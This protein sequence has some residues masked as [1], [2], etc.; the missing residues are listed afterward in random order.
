M[1]RFTFSRV[2]MMSPSDEVAEPDPA[3]PEVSCTV[4]PAT[5]GD[6]LPSDGQVRGELRLFYI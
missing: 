6:D 2:A 1:S 4:A 3:P 5:N